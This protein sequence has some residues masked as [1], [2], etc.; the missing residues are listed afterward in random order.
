MMLLRPI[1]SRLETKVG[2]HVIRREVEAF[3]N[4]R[5]TLDLGCGRSPNAGAFPNRVGMDIEPGR[6]VHVIAD[7]HYL[8]FAANSF[9]QIVCSEVLEHLADPAQAAREMGRVVNDGGQLFLTTPFVYPV[10]EAPY[11]YQRFT[12]YGLTRLFDLAGFQIRQIKPLFDEEQTLAILIQRIAFQRQDSR[13]RHYFYLLLAH[14]IY[15]LAA[16]AKGQRY[17][18]VNRRVAG[19]FMT[20]G[21]LLVAQKT[22]NGEH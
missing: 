12:V 17:Q 7:A 22:G 15:G 9:Q 6:G 18:H 8:P 2:K 10:H 4:N 14:L 19:P 21:Y 13:L 1:L 11:D 5:Q 20:A 16:E 3:A